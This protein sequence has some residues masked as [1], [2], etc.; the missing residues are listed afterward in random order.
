MANGNGLSLE[1][2]HHELERLGSL[3]RSLSTQIASV[4]VRVSDLERWDPISGRGELRLLG[5]DTKKKGKRKGKGKGKGK[6]KQPGKGKGK[7]K[8]NGNGK[9]GWSGR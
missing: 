5:K 6:G 2:V 7:G 4:R 1:V 8:G 3:V 9:R